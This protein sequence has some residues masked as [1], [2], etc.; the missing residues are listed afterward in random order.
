MSARRRAAPR[1]PASRRAPA[2]SRRGGSRRGARCAPARAPSARR[3][4]RSPASPRPRG[5][6]GR[7]AGSAPRRRPR[8]PWSPRLGIPLIASSIAVFQFALRTPLRH[9]KG[10]NA[11]REPLPSSESTQILPP[12]AETRPCAMKSPR[13]V[14]GWVSPPGRTC[15][16]SGRCCDAGMPFPLVGDGDLDAIGPLARLDAARAPRPA[17]T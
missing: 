15:R 3:P 1:R 9:R 4:P 14:P 13:P 17:S 8:E 10:S 12:I 5:S 7:A 16:R 6:R 11:N 2:S